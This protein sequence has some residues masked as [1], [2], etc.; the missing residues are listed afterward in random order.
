MLDNNGNAAGLLSKP[1]VLRT[2]ARTDVIILVL[3]IFGSYIASRTLLSPKGGIVIGLFQRDIII[4]N[5]QLLRYHRGLSQ[6]MKSISSPS[7]WKIIFPVDN[8]KSS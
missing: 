5:S 7:S 6:N 1:A 3:I 2:A 8:H 4:L